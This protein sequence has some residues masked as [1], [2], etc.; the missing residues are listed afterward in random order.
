[1]HLL[2]QPVPRQRVE[3]AAD[4]HVG[5]PEQ[6][7]ELADARGAS[8]AHRLEDALLSLLGQHLRS[9]RPAEP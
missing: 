9:R 7:R 8:I 4:G 6:S 2:E 1:V 5:H 3:V